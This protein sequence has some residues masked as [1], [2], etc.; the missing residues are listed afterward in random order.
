[1]HLNFM[2]NIVCRSLYFS[3]PKLCD[4]RQYLGLRI[5]LKNQK[6]EKHIRGG[7]ESE[8]WRREE[9][10][11]FS[12]SGRH[13]HFTKGL[14]KLRGVEAEN[15]PLEALRFGTWH[16]F[17]LGVDVLVVGAAVGRTSTAA[18]K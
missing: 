13:S 12:F 9:S 18:S 16:T 7:M 4:L 6:P 5:R 1:M 17:F 2:I 15:S 14:G 10:N 11:S 8:Y 3:S